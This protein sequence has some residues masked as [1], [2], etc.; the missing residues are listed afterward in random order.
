MK[1]F[2]AEERGECTGPGVALIGSRLNVVV[3]L[4]YVNRGVTS[5]DRGW[6]FNRLFGGSNASDL[7]SSVEGSESS[8]LVGLRSSASSN[9]C[10]VLVTVLRRRVAFVDGDGCESS[11]IKLVR[12]EKGGGTSFKVDS[13]GSLVPR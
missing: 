5:R 7:G 4:L 3:I 9:V 2:G 8:I 13:E 12:D 1:G 10:G 11:V 6:C